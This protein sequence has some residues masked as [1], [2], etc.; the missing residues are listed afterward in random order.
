VF[1]A[2]GCKPEMTDEEILAALLA[3]NLE[4]AVDRSVQTNLSERTT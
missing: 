1:T 3:L 2:Y 4:R